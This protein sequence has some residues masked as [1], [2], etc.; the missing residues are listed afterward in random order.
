LS[1][2][3]SLRTAL[4]G[5]SHL[6]PTSNILLQVLNPARDFRK[7]MISNDKLIQNVTHM[8]VGISLHEA[9]EDS[10]YI[11]ALVIPCG[12][13]LGSPSRNLGGI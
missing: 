12:E 1:H 2:C 6:L 13:L 8:L 4:L 11:R 10:L 7:Y 5:Q 9:I 3:Q